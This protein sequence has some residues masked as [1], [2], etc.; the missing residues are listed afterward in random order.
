MIYIP[1]LPL[2]LEILR[3]C[4]DQLLSGH[5]G[6]SKTIELVL[7]TFW[8]P[9]LRTFVKNYIKSCN[10][11]SRSKSSHHKP[12]GL[13][14]PLSVPTR[15]WQSFSMDFITDLPSSN[16][17]D[18]ILVVVDRFSKMSHFI[19]CNKAI[20]AQQTAQLIMQNV[21]R[22]HG[23][24]DNIVSDRGT[25]F[26]SKFWT[27]LF[28]LLGTKINLSS[29]Y[30]PQSDGQTEIV[31]QIL[32]QYLRCTINYQQDNWCS[33]LPFAEFAYN[34]T[35]HSSTKKTPFYAN[36]GF[37]PQFNILTPNISQNPSAENQITELHKIHEQ[38]IYNLTN[39]QK[40]Y[41]EQ[42]D[43]HRIQHPFKVGDSVWLLRN[44]IKTTRPSNKLDYKRLG[45][46]KI[47]AQINQVSFRLDLPS[48][49]KIHNVFHVSQ[50]EPSLPTKFP[51]RK[52]EPPHPILIDDILEYEVKDILDFKIIRNKPHYLVDWK[53]YDPSERSWEPLENLKHAQ[54]VIKKFHS[55]YP[56]NPLPRSQ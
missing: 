44:N 9:N 39:A 11:C 48:T 22:L 24:P 28:E 17:F 7:R 34:N 31:N 3:C 46:F 1:T 42:A 36:Y 6:L 14:N 2:Q 19:P 20:S 32:E 16:N 53:G 45:P 51:G 38:L 29:A 10:V 55:K 35:I 47:S 30:H 43:K 33:L 5:F 27:R 50:L 49:L 4:H 26:V 15:P 21:V 56:T 12:Y 23:L 52:Q 25:Q 18:S 8:W 13:L 54:L 41:K 37:H 40:R